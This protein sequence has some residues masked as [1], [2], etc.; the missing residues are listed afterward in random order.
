MLDNLIIMRQEIMLILIVLILLVSEIFMDKN[1]GK[2]VFIA[3]L[4]FAVHTAV[5]FLPAKFG[6]IFGEMYKNTEMINFM[7]SDESKLQRYPLLL[8]M[9]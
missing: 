8:W 3:T 6:F 7:K 2:M 5:G 1:R 9:Q 4:L